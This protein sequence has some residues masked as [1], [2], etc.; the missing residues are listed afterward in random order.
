MND[1]DEASFDFYERELNNNMDEGESQ[2]FD[3][4]FGEMGETVDFG[5]FHQ[6]YSNITSGGFVFD[7]ICGNISEEISEIKCYP[8]PDALNPCEDVMGYVA[9]RISVWIVVALAVFGNV[10]VLVVLLTNR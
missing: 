1:S 9:L 5:Q 2:G 7:A 6:P 8:A 4:D 3:N 10:F